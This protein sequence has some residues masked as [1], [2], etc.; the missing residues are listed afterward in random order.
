MLSQTIHAREWE[1]RRDLS[2]EAVAVARRLDDA[3]TLIAVLPVAYQ[4][5]G[6]EGREQRLVDTADAIELARRQGNPTAGCNALF[7]RI[8]A[9]LQ[10]A[11]LAEVD[12]R[13]AELTTEARAIGLPLH[14]W[15]LHMTTS[16]R[17]LIDGRVEEPRPRRSRR[18][19]SGPR[20]GTPRPWPPTG[21]SC[22]R[23]V[24]S[25]GGWER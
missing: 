20:A 14:L 17:A 2:T 23:S 22:S 10:E 25:R 13:L 19:G 6:P 11:D 3:D 1:R 4:H 9:C 8:D 18:S 21:S 16:L 12:R 5:Y 7:H 15:Q 24:V